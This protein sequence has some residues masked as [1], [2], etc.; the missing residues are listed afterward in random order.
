MAYKR[1]LHVF[2][3]LIISATLQ[4]GGSMKYVILYAHPNP[5]SFNHAILEHVQ[6][7]LKRNGKEFILR[8]LYSMK[9]N[10]VLD[11]PDFVAM[12]K[13]QVLADVEQEQKFIKD[14]DKIIVIHPVW[15]Y[16]MPAMMKG[17][18]DRVFTRGFAYDYDATG[19]KGL[20]SGKKIVIFNTTGGSKEIYENNGFKKAINLAIETGTYELCGL[21]IEQHVYFYAVPTIGNDGRVKMLKDIDGMNL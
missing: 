18:I 8:D 16:G 3:P 15:W 1:A 17:Y 11:A 7:N 19:V 13:K 6:E 14:A 4:K 5:K 2:R 20:L 12:G 21:K 10:P 9:F